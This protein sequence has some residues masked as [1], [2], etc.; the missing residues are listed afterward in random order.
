MV[1]A[2]KTL[3]AV[4][5]LVLMDIDPITFSLA[6]GWWTLGLL[7]EVRVVATVLAAGTRLLHA[8]A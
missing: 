4:V 8:G 1:T 2:R 3:T 5:L 6:T 7:M